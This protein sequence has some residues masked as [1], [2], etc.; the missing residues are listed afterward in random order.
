LVLLTVPR[1]ADPTAYERVVFPHNEER[2]RVVLRREPVAV[3][4]RPLPWYFCRMKLAQSRVTAQGQIS[5]PVEVRR[6]LVLGPGS[7]SKWDVDDDTVTV[8]RVGTSTSE[9][10]HRALFPKAPKPRTLEELKEGPARYARE[11]HARR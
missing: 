7:I 9:D 10:V 5:V 3:A 11:R 8:R 6:R 2:L 1:D 4:A